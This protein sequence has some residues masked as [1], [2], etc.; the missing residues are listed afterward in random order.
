ME[1][2]VFGKIFDAKVFNSERKGG[3]A[4]G[5]VPEA[6]GVFCGIVSIR[7]YFST[8]CLKSVV[9]ASLRLYMPRRM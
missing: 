6:G 9:P 1:V 8:I 4:R 3:L 7:G 2:V 5:V